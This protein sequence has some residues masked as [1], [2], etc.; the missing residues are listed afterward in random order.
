MGIRIDRAIRHMATISAVL[1]IGIAGNARA[2]GIAQIIHAR[3]RHFHELA[4][5]AH[6]LQDQIGRSHPDWLVVTA[7]ANRIGHLASALPS[8]FPA[9]SGKGHGV[10]T[11]ARKTIWLHPHEFARFARR[12]LRRA[13]N[14]KEAVASRALGAAR[15]RARKLGQSCD[16]CHRRFRGSSSLWH[17]W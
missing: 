4:R 2:T 5:T 10:N 16:S 6:S 14:L 11:R 7:D 9:G 12:I 3:Q 13:Q 1:L 17:L 8:W 15:L